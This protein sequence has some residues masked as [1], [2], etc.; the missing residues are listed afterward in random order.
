M[1][2][3]VWTTTKIAMDNGHSCT[4]KIIISKIFTEKVIQ[5]LSKAYIILLKIITFEKNIVDKVG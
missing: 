5:K 1:A 4:M 2:I 3:R